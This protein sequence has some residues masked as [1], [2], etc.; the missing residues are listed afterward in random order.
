MQLRP[1][2]TTSDTASG[3]GCSVSSRGESPE[4]WHSLPLYEEER[5]ATSQPERK[6]GNVVGQRSKCLVI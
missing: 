6:E 1:A 4:S 5:E 2:I 3:D